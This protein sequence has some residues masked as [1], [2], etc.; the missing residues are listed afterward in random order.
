MTQAEFNAAPGGCTAA[1]LP[2]ALADAASLAPARCATLWIGDALGKVERACLRSVLRQGH[3]LGFYCYDVPSGVPSGVTIRDAAQILPRDRIIHYCSG[4]VALFAN[5]FRYELQRRG[6]GTWV[7]TDIYL[8]APIDSE[9]PYLFGYESPACINNAI[10]RIPPRSP[11]LPAL[12]EPFEERVV[13]SWLP[14]LHRVRAA[15]R[16]AAHGKTDLSKMPWGSTGP[17]ALSAMAV[18]HGLDHWALPQQVFYPAHYQNASW[19]TDPGLE[20][21]DVVSP[22]TIAIH[23]WNEVIKPY[24]D[25]PSAA[26]SFLA[27]LHREGS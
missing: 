16:L 13:P 15:I 26:G 5:W 2:P 7:D 21:A 17:R 18:A 25:E 9:R 14:W 10:L 3:S 27:R 4:S 1:D 8:L 23:L 12:I 6:L 22:D 20:L 24:K 19:I 11:M